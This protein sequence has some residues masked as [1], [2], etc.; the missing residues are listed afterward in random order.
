MNNYFAF[1]CKAKVY[2][3]CDLRRFKGKNTETLSKTQYVKMW[4]RII[5]K[6]NAAV[7]TE[8]KKESVL[9]Q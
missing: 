9:N 4:E 3:Y 1:Y 8:K 2:K 7:T 6:M 5:K